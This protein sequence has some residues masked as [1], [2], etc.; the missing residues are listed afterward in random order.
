MSCVYDRIIKELKLKKTT[1]DK[2]L[3]YLQ[4]NNKLTTNV[5][6]Q[7]EELST[8]QLQENYN[9]IKEISNTDQGYDCSTCDPLLLLI[10]ELYCVSITH[11]FS[12][13]MVVYTNINAN[14][15]KRL[16]ISSSL[17]HMF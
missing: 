16:I 2:L 1:P 12:D 15:K 7:Y 8:K 17:D 3:K 13:S 5:L 14:S 11:T 6:W 9:R 4:K 10:C